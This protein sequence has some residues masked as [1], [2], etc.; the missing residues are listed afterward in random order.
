M[1]PRL[2]LDRYRSGWS[3]CAAL[4]AA[5]PR[6]EWEWIESAVALVESALAARDY[7]RSRREPPCTIRVPSAAIRVGDTTVY[8]VPQGKHLPTH[9]GAIWLSRDEEVTDECR[10]SLTTHDVA[11][12]V[13]QI[14]VLRSCGERSR[15]ERWLGTLGSHMD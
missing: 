6:E 14:I 11:A 10:T 15:V 5:M 8:F 9:S 12:F 7:A 2:A 4:R 13:A 3:L 1:I